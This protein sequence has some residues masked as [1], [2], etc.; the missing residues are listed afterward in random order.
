MS[1]LSISQ[2]TFTVASYT[3]VNLYRSLL[4][5]Q[6][7]ATF[8]FP[9]ADSMYEFTVLLCNA[10]SSCRVYILNI[11]VCS[12]SLV[13][14]YSCTPT[15]CTNDSE[16]TEVLRKTK[17]QLVLRTRETERTRGARAKTCI[18]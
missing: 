9:D 16:L 2:S 15:R 7:R 13:A 17:L 12:C 4:A 18:N 5:N 6:C 11:R 10:A 14:V 1:A 3:A 8:H